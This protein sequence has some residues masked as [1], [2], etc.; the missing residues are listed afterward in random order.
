[1]K[2]TAGAN[3]AGFVRKRFVWQ[4]PL[5][6]IL[7]LVLVVIVFGQHMTAS[8]GDSFA[9]GDSC[10]TVVSRATYLIDLSKPVDADHRSLP[11]DLLQRLSGEATANTELEVYAVSPYKEAPRTLVGRLCKPFGNAELMLAAQTAFPAK[12]PQSTPPAA[13]LAGP[14]KAAS[15]TVPAADCDDLHAQ[16]RG[17]L[18]AGAIRFCEERAAL[19]RRIDALVDQVAHRA[20]A[21]SYLVEALNDTMRGFADTPVPASLHVFS[22]MMQHAKWYSHLDLGWRAWDAGAF[23]AAWNGE[24]TRPVP[25]WGDAAGVTV[26]YVPRNGFTADHRPRLVHK[27]FWEGFFGNAALVFEDQPAMSTYSAEPL[28]DVMRDVELAAYKREQARYKALLVERDR[29]ALTEAQRELER[30]RLALAQ[31]RQEIAEQERLLDQ[32]LATVQPAHADRALAREM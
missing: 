3:F 12:A 8:A 24:L 20:V 6:L 11:G 25:P 16:V 7:G 23:E 17:S 2:K 22:D 31:R 18:R 13:T 4:G 32:R 10:R 1:M 5:A 19:R 28:M 21:S 9:G 15:D 27:A 29:A 26:F 14:A 30:D